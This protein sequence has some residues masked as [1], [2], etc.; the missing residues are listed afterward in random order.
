[1]GTTLKL[2]RSRGESE[3]DAAFQEFQKFN[4]GL[5]Q[6]MRRAHPE[7]FDKQLLS[8]YVSQGLVSVALGVAPH[9][10]KTVAVAL[11]LTFEVRCM[12]PYPS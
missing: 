5:R 11:A 12:S 4:P 1:V 8:Y 6:F 10:R 7:D 3:R 9:R 2:A